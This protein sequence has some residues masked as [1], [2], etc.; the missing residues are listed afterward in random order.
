MKELDAK[1]L[2]RI[3]ADFVRTLAWLPLNN[4]NQFDLAHN[5]AVTLANSYTK[6]QTAMTVIEAHL[7]REVEIHQRLERSKCLVEQM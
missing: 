6:P 3:R 5:V 7:L 4:T 1:E 2:S